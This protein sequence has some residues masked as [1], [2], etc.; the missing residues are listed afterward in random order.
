MDV[1]NTQRVQTTSQLAA[2]QTQ[3]TAALASDFETFLKMLT[4]QAR[5]QDPLEPIDSSEYAAQLAQFSMVEQQVLSNDLLTGL[6][7]QLGAN[8]IG[9]MA[10]WI[11]MEAR[12]TAATSFAGDPV[13]ILPKIEPG[14][15]QAMLV[16]YDPDGRVVQRRQ[17]ETDGEALEWTGILDDGSLAPEGNY[18]FKVESLQLGEIT[19]TSS[20]ETYTRITEAR[21]TG[22]DTVFVLNSGATVTAGE[23]TALREAGL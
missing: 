3:T 7:D 14:A 4:A 5:Y 17:I 6:G 13:T 12:S 1:T 10:A 16:A 20:A 18:S 21:R 8:S 11:G 2:T 9:Q 22:E 15:D 23:I 19:G